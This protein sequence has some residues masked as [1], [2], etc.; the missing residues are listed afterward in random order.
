[1]NEASVQPFSNAEAI[2]YGWRT[3][4]ANLRPLLILSALGGFFALVGGA[5]RDRGGGA[6]LLGVGIQVLQAGVALALIRVAL[7]LHDGRS[8]DFERSG[9]T[10]EGFFPYLLTTALY[11]VVVVCGT[12]LLIVPGVIWAIQF[13]FAGFLVADARL[14]PIEAMRA[15]SRLTRGVKSQLLGFGLM[16]AGVNLLGAMALGVGLLVTVPTTCLAAAFVFRRLQIREA[17]GVQQTAPRREV[18]AM[19]THAVAS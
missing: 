17:A 13:C 3:T 9:A 15:S 6:G 2:R 12:A 16:L 8:A 18:P 5:L 7:R 10:L 11:G 1:M 14:D 19:G 4:Q